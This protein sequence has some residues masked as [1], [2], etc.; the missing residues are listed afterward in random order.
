M[1]KSITEKQFQDTIDDGIKTVLNFEN[2]DMVPHFIYCYGGYYYGYED[3]L[4][5]FIMS[6]MQNCGL[7]SLILTTLCMVRY[8]LITKENPKQRTKAS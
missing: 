1:R 4:E 7:Q 3:E 8:N 5:K 2:D 6:R